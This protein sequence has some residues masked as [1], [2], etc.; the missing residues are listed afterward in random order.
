MWAASEFRE[1]S[2]S[3]VSPVEQSCEQI[4]GVCS[5]DGWRASPGSGGM[6]RG[7]DVLVELLAHP[8]SDDVRNT[9][10]S[11]GSVSRFFRIDRYPG[12]RLHRLAVWVV[13]GGQIADLLRLLKGQFKKAAQHGGFN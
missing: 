13:G 9:S 5:A 4:K 6:S 3:L 1:F 8:V 12:Q 7:G 10:G 2:R 11:T